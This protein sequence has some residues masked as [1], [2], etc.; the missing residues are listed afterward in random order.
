MTDVNESAVEGADYA[1]GAG[2]RSVEESAAIT[3]DNDDNTETMNGSHETSV[4]NGATN[5]SSSH[6]DAGEGEQIG[7]THQ[8]PTY[9]P[10]SPSYET[11]HKMEDENDTFPPF[12]SSPTASALTVST[13]AT[14]IT[15]NTNM[16]P[17]LSVSSS[18]NVQRRNK[19]Q[20]EKMQR[21]VP[22]SLDLDYITPQIIGMAPPRVKPNDAGLP[23][24]QQ[25]GGADLVQK[26]LNRQQSSKKQKRFK[27]NDPGELSTFLERRHP[28]RYLLFNVS[29]DDADDRSLLLLGRQVVHLPWGSPRRIPHPPS[30][31]LSCSPMRTT[32][33]VG[34]GGAD[35]SSPSPFSYFRKGTDGS[36]GVGNNAA[37]SSAAGGGGSGSNKSASGTPAVSRVM[38]ICYAL[39][40]YLSIPPQEL[41][42]ELLQDG[43]TG[44]FKQSS[45]RQRRGGG[46]HTAALPS[47]VACIYCGNGKTRTGV[48]VACYLRFCN[49]VPNALSG[50]EI[51]CERRGIMSSGASAAASSSVVDNT[52][53]ISSHIPPSLRQFFSNFDDVVHRKHY[54]HPEPLLLQSIQLQGVP[55]DDMPC[56]DIW[57][58]GDVVRGQIYSSHDD[59]NNND[60]TSISMNEWDDEEGS[61]KIGQVIDQDF[62]LVC[63]FGGEFAEDADDP[64]KVLFR[65]VNCPNF[66]RDGMLELGMADVDMMR[67]YADSFDDEEFLLTM[68]FEAVDDSMR[69]YGS[70]GGRNKKGS[71]FFS[72]SR[73]GAFLPDGGTKFNGHIH[74]ESDLILQGWR[75]LSDA[76]LSHPLSEYKDELDFDSS[77]SFKK[78][79]LGNEIDFLFIALQFTNGDA[80]S[81][82]AELVNGLFK[83]FFYRDNIQQQ[84]ILMG[85]P[86]V[87]EENVVRYIQ[88]PILEMGEVEEE[89]AI[90]RRA[91]LSS[92]ATDNDQSC[93]TPIELG[94]NQDAQDQEDVPDKEPVAG[95]TKDAVVDSKDE[96]TSQPSTPDRL[97]NHNDE[98]SEPALIGIIG[99]FDSMDESRGA[100]LV[101][102]LGQNTQSIESAQPELPNVENANFSARVENTDAKS[103]DHSVSVL[104]G[105]EKISTTNNAFADQSQST[106]LEAIQMRGLKNSISKVGGNDNRSSLL[107]DIRRTKSN[108]AATGESELPISVEN[109]AAGVNNVNAGPVDGL[110]GT[111][112]LDSAGVDIVFDNIDLARIED[113][114]IRTPLTDAGVMMI[115]LDQSV[116]T[117]YDY[118][119]DSS[120]G[121]GSN[122]EADNRTA[123]PSEANGLNPHAEDTRSQIKKDVVSDT[124]AVAKPVVSTLPMS[125][126]GNEDDVPSIAALTAAASLKKMTPV[127]NSNVGET[128]ADE[129]PTTAT[130]EQPPLN[131]NP[132][133]EKYYRMLK[134]GLPMGAVKNAVQRDELDPTILELDP[135][136]SLESQRPIEKT[137]A[138]ASAQAV[139][140]EHS[141]VEPHPATV[142]EMYTDIDVASGSSIVE[143][144]LQTDDEK[145]PRA[146]HIPTATIV[147][148]GPPPLNEDP[149]YEK[150]F[151]MLKMGLP[152]GAVKNA[153][154]LDELDP[155]ILDLDPN[156]PVSSQTKESDDGNGTSSTV[157]RE[158][159]RSKDVKATTPPST[160]ALPSDHTD[161]KSAL[162]AMFAK[163][164]GQQTV[165]QADEAVEEDEDEALMDPRAALMTMLSKRAPPISP[166]GHEN[167]SSGCSDA[168]NALNTMFAK[169]DGQSIEDQTDKAVTTDEDEKAVN[170]RAA[171]M[172]MLSKRAP[173]TQAEDPE[174]TPSDVPTDHNDA[175]NA[176]NAMF[177]QRSGGQ[178]SV[179]K[180]DETAVEEETVD[181]RA[182]LMSMLSKR[183]PPIPADE[184]KNVPSPE[185]EEEQPDPRAALMSMLNK[186]APPTLAEESKNSSPEEEEREAD[187]RAALMSMLN[188]RA[189]PTP[190]EEPDNSSPEEEEKQ[191]DPRAA[192]LSMLS[193]RAPPIPADEPD[194]SSPEEEEEQVDPRA[195]LMSML[196]KRAPPIRAD[197]SKIEASPE[198]EEKEA[199]PR[200]ALM[201]M[202]SKRVPPTPSE[203]PKNSSP[204]EE[205]KQPDPRAALMSMLSNRTSPT[206]AEEPKNAS[207]EEEEREADPRAALMSMLSQRAPPLLSGEPK[208]EASPEEEEKQ[209]DPRAA[210]MSMLSN[211]APPIPA[212]ESKKAQ[213]PE[214]EETQ[215]DP[216]AAL[217]SML[218]KRAS[219]PDEPQSPPPPSEEAKQEDPRAALMS[220][221]SKRASPT[222]ADD[223]KVDAPKLAGGATAGASALTKQA[224]GSNDGAQS[225]VKPPDAAKENDGLPTIREDPR[226]S[227]YFKMIKM[228]LPMGAVKNAML[229]DQQDPTVMD[230]DP[231]RSFESQRPPEKDNGGDDGPPLNKDPTYEKYFK[232]MKM[233]L[234]MGAVK[235]AIQR[236]G[237][238]P[239]IMDLDPNKSVASQTKK[240][241][242]G[243]PL[244]EDPKYSKYFKMLKMGLPMGAVKNAIQRDGLDP[245]MMDLDPEKSI[246]SQLKTEEDDGPPLKE[247][248]K[249]SKYFKMLKMGLPMGAVKN[250]V[251]RDGLDPSIMDLDP[252]KSVG[253]QID[254]DEDD[255]PPL[256][257]EE[258][259]QKYFKMLKMGLPMGAVKNAVERDGLDP[260]IMD[261]DPEKSIASQ[262]DKEEEIVDKGPPLK[263]DPTYSKYFKMLKMGL[264]MGAVQNAIQRD[265]H[266]PSIMDLDPEKS[267]EYQ[268]AMASSKGKKTTKKKT[269][270]KPKKPKVRRKK[271]FWSPIEESKIDD[272][273]LWSMV[274]GTFDFD[275]L[276]VDQD[277]FESLFT[278]SSNPKDKKKTAAEKPAASKQKK[279]VQVIDAK[280]GMNGGIILARIKV[281][282]SAMAEMVNEMDCGKLDDTQLKA[283][284]EFLPTKD[285]KFAIEGYVKGASSS[286]KTKEAAINDF[287]ACEKYMLAMMKV[288]MA[289]EKFECMLFKYQF[290]IKLKELMDGVTTLINSCE[291]VQKSVRLR[292]LMAMILM[293]GNQINTGGSGTM[294]Q[295]FTLDALLKLDE[296]KAF[297]KKTSVL[298][299][300][301]KLVKANEPDLLNVHEE[302]PSIGPAQNVIVDTLVSELK[303][304][305]DQLISVKG[306]AASEGRRIRDGKNSV[307]NETALDRLRSQKTKIKDV[308]GVHMYNRAVPI[309]LTVM[310]KFALYA[311]KRTKE[312][313]A[314]IE[315]VQE[316]FKGVLSYF[317]ENPAMSSTDFFGTL[318]K[319]IATFDS[320]REVVKRIEALK[321]AEE[322]KE[323]AR[324][325]KEATKKAAKSMAAAKA[326]SDVVAQQSKGKLDLSGQRKKFADPFAGPDTEAEVNPEPGNEG[327]GKE[328][329]PSSPGAKLKKELRSESDQE[330]K[331]VD[332]RA[333]LMSMLSKRAPPTPAEAPKNALSSEEEA[334][335]EDSRAALMSMLS[336]R[337]PPT[338]ADEPKS[339]PSP[340]K[341]EKQAD[342]RAALM[343][344]LSKR[345]PPTPAEEAKTDAS[346][347]DASPEVE[348]KQEDP[349]AALMSMLS[350]RA[351]PTPVEEPK[352]EAPPTRSQTGKGDDEQNDP[353]SALSAMLS[354]RVP[355]SP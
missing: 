150:Y 149:S 34:G 67:R 26:S 144:D 229:R 264:P 314:R 267:L 156:M 290:D 247:D 46:K 327:K 161:A 331:Q 315:E 213:S 32:P 307:P 337:A 214:E 6:H 155:A 14:T 323:A 294:A 333:A 220:M 245:S 336:K 284:R 194:K 228:G 89:K 330:T 159:E 110:P 39:H 17:N 112:I 317:G 73:R 3:A 234:P 41:P 29:D 204:E 119:K 21:R 101:S 49:E 276:K 348:E 179:E 270:A 257:D 191:A 37:T 132:T 216:R 345:A 192:L 334:K 310:E 9:R 279:S 104:G 185:E 352:S 169:R 190:A 262:L 342:P 227:K 193:K 292:K 44:G 10:S 109:D 256:K 5:E 255:G 181:P 240:D 145:K 182:A 236:D 215:H 127:D 180:I 69:C 90:E 96:T 57:E 71:S 299:Y 54:P 58:H 308:E 198:E 235:N 316:N 102:K 130:I 85:P 224:P 186:R 222:G 263:D 88:Q 239:S 117:G 304:L 111:S 79:C 43:T 94:N 187:P 177:T 205:E 272:N 326:I 281:E 203:E 347:H 138:V 297:D 285:E 174:S 319:F 72:S 91:S 53:D 52:K 80:D 12:P 66:L 258:K 353:K 242:D 82:N 346:K 1:I 136:R 118:G 124:S 65:Y 171:L 105:R 269:P 206:P 343:S 115:G 137:D 349:R 168:Q 152:R 282:F 350:K 22:G 238:D 325:A 254:K 129:V 143:G 280:R 249:Y 188:K 15:N 135:E 83:S 312:A 278:D 335:P 100:P 68:I 162:N 33:G 354:K 121:E 324:R 154:Q 296:A 4:T 230:L 107:M 8:Q 133:Y 63:R 289:D 306:T 250:A 218:S 16:S 189:P 273:S 219:P 36:S 328:S 64:S 153:M 31:E 303:E 295:G 97:G 165:E 175:K 81:A 51:F 24:Q 120:L 226:F 173:P 11:G 251:E 23:Q 196:S 142:D 287:C 332:P 74:E 244:K 199:D 134:M 197:E 321:I 233:G 309:E 305:N 283:L 59:Y 313:F 146:P 259:Y 61:Y 78:S 70:P 172:S 148:T 243:P 114:S 212:E 167:E 225:A 20:L 7:N 265:G 176:L 93:A 293:L 141:H 123:S 99:Q 87:V 253:S 28:R 311:E 184:P 13:D 275:S 76:H 25:Q 113:S 128:F 18:S 207:P 223:A 55:V 202:L 77:P 286:S 30:H 35:G 178:Q 208:I 277:E 302:M 131:K 355:Q 322:K 45:K 92:V 95:N 221:I 158:E 2:D 209:V 301:V 300:L 231:E 125:D 298:Q 241:D 157:E 329:S 84:P 201:S 232:M 19:K 38:D 48:I 106:L 260:S 164:S 147:K 47:T 318:N 56:V 122:Y 274:R 126:A 116:S 211:R 291:E 252:E 338:S 271:I 108:E 351:P 268:K 140:G 237:L 266:D 341:E 27:G 163:R 170:P 62:T 42:P 261:L 103:M 139:T 183:A 340:K 195:A 288:E 217:M 320:A 210:L 344:M 151:K 50:F 248:P 60:D 75:V 86:E 200:A 98:N 160:T 246:A 339:P 40:A 166:D